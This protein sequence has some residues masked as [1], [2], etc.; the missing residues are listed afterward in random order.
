MRY[1]QERTHRTHAQHKYTNKKGRTGK[2]N[3]QKQAQ[4]KLTKGLL[5]M[6]IL[7]FLNEQPMHGYQV[8]TSIRRNY[9]VYFGPSTIYPLLSSLEKKGQVTSTW[10][11]E[12]E[13]PRKIYKLTSEGHGLLTCTE[14][15]LSLIVKTLGNN[16]TK[17]EYETEQKSAT[18]TRFPKRMK[19]VVGVTR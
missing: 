5:D 19:L 9:G 15:T 4:T 12:G 8:I 13:R 2:M 7:E 1:A 14:N 11:M 10:N 16:T 6:I 3:S 18:I 17:H